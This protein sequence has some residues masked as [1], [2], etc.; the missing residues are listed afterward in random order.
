M[1]KKTVYSIMCPKGG[2][3]KTHIA[4]LLAS[5][6]KCLNKKTKIYDNDSE[7]PRL[8]KYKALSTEHIQLHKLDSNGRVKAE[9]LN[10]N[11]M[12]VITNELEHGGHEII[13]IDNG[14]PSFQPFL[15]YFQVDMVDMFKAINIDFIIIIP[16]TKDDLTH[17][18]PIELLSSYCNSVKYILVE[19]GHFG[20]F[21]YDDSEF[22]K[23]NVDYAIIKL[24]RY[25]NA[26]MEDVNRAQEYNLLFDEAVHNKEF[27]LV[28][29]SRLNKAQKEFQDIF[30]TILNDFRGENYGE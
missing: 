1:Q 7:T 29:K 26:Q 25:T 15:S 16:I 8:S 10:I 20:E 12:D 23:N 27:N 30:I 11:K 28:S 6:I 18:A 24:E 19:N 14:S 22:K 17:D 2:V 3:G 13:I 9:S 4:T 5:S 21:D